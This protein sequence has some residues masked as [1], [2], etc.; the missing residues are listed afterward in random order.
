[1]PGGSGNGGTTG[2]GGTAASD[3]LRLSIK[4]PAVAAGQEDHVCVVRELPNQ[5]ALWVK[6]IHATLTVGS[7]HLIVDRVAATT[8]VQTRPR[9]VRRRW[10]ARRAA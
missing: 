8:P 3:E 6:A 7:H 10:A 9:R 5:N 4:M 2:A 1:M